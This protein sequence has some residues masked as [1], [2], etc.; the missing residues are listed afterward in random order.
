MAKDTYNIFIC[1]F[2]VGDDQHLFENVNSVIN[3]KHLNFLHSIL[4]L[5]ISSYSD[6]V[7]KAICFVNQNVSVGATVS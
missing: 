4:L 2:G 7:G 3:Y 1:L 6:F 5:I